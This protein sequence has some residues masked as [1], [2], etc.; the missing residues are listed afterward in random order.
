MRPLITDALYVSRTPVISAPNQLNALLADGN[1]VADWVQAIGLT[2]STNAT[3]WA[4]RLNGVSLA[5]HGT[6]GGPT[7]GADGSLTF[8][9]TDQYMR[10]SFALVQPETI[11]LVLKQIAWSDNAYI[12]DGVPAN[13]GEMM[14]ITGGASPQISICSNGGINIVGPNSNLAVGAWGV[15]IAQFNGATSLLQVDSN[16]AVTGNAGAGNLGGF[17]IGTDGG[18]PSQY[19]NIA[20]KRIILR[21]VADD[22]AKILAIQTQ[23]K[24]T[25]GTP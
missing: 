23:L 22:A 8:N 21:S 13:R 7:I 12:F 15:V 10:A 18:G 25:Y 16:T 17:T 20:V 24:A 11:Y 4:D 3:A 2:G 19:A 1:T 5:G 14:Q 6:G 9:G